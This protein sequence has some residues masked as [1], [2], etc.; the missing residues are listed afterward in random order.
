MGKEEINGHLKNLAQK[1]ENRPDAGPVKFPIYGG[2]W[3]VEKV[4]FKSHF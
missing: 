4:S 3:N 2:Y 1:L